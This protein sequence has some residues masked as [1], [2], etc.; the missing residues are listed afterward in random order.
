MRARALIS[1]C[2]LVI[3]FTALTAHA[4]NKKAVL[5]IDMQ[6]GFYD[7]GAARST[8]LQKLV[9]NQIQLL[10]KA[11]A[12]RTPVIVLQYN[13]WDRTDDR[14]MAVIKNHPHVV[15]WKSH[16]S[17]F[18]EPDLEKQLQSWGIGTLVVAGVNGCCCVRSTVSDA[19]D[20]GYKVVTSPYL[21]AE[22]YETP[23]VF[24]SFTWYPSTNSSFAAFTAYPQLTRLFD[25][26]F[27]VKP[28]K[29]T[30]AQQYVPDDVAE[31]WPDSLGSHY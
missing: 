7:G 23:P 24:P 9:D 31:S 26:H 14:L 8:E 25:D 4:A 15:I 18:V 21:V 16:D 10:K 28:V 30:V 6:Y 22:L 2:L 3:S 19:L 13:G 29:L 12:T 20:H 5:L 27:P 11:V 17:G 1:Y